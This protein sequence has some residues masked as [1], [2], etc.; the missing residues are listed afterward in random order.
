MT[1]L[2]NTLKDKLDAAPWNQT[3]NP[4]QYSNFPSP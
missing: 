2:E 1:N 4:T 3:Q